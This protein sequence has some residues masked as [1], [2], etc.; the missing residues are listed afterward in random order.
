MANSL[1]AGKWALV[2]GA[3]SGLGADFARNL[4]GRG[5]HI[6]LVAR[7]IERLETLAQ[8]LRT[9][10]NVETHV[11]A[12]DLA[13]PEAPAR[14]YQ[15]VKDLGVHIEVLINNAGFGIYG[16]FIETPWQRLNEMLQVNIMAVCHLTRLFAPDMVA[17]KSGYILQIASIGAYQPSPSYAAYSAA[18][19][20]ILFWGEALN[21][22]LR[23]HGVKVTV[24]SPG[25]TRTDFLKVSGQQATPYQRLLMMR[26]P[27]VVRIGL[28]ALLKGKTSIVPG[29]LNR[30]FA[31]LNR[32]MPR[33]LAA[34]LSARAMDMD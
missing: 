1:L 6:V 33:R 15:Q 22:E 31:W 9:Q 10:R 23:P 19:S 21:Y 29:A 11:V 12:L 4:A 8:E 24:L 7:R 32:L 3:S 14:L 34:A 20:F 27:D 25:V 5:M 13:E 26:S 2:T 16:Q 18:K 30:F 17:R 28:D